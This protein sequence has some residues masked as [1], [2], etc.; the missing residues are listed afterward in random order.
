MFVKLEKGNPSGPRLPVTKCPCVA[1][2]LAVVGGNVCHARGGVK[3]AGAPTGA[4]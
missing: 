2:R 3:G 4:V 1:P